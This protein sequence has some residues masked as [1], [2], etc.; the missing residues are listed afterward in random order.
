MSFPPYS[1]K[2]LMSI[3][4]SSKIATLFKFVS[5]VLFH[6]SSAI[7]DFME[8]TADYSFP[9]FRSPFPVPRSRSPLPAPRS[10]FPVLVTSSIFFGFEARCLFS[11]VFLIK[12][13]RIKAGYCVQPR[14]PNLRSRIKEQRT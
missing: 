3:I 11:V 2:H 10:P 8:V 4:S 6:R 1:F 7:L 14:F 12:G 5:T 13:M 9:D